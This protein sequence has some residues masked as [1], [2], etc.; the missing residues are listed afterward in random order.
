MMTKDQLIQ[1]TSQSLRLI[2][3]EYHLSQDVFSEMIGITK[4]TLVQIEKDRALASWSVVIAVIMLFEDCQILKMNLKEE[5][6]RVLKSIVFDAIELP[7][8]Q[9]MG[10]KMFWRTLKKE[11]GFIIQQNYFSGHYRLVDGMGKRFLSSYHRNDIED[12]LKEVS[13][14]ELS[15]EEED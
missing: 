3:N 2:R 13:M 8:N 14:K 9:T 12:W 11:A 15:D 7:K 10:G 6:S 4:K 5:P 1:I